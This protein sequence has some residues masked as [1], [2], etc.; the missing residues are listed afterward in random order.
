MDEE[1]FEVGASDDS[2]S[3]DD[4]KPVEVKRVGRPRNET[5]VQATKQTVSVMFR[6]NR[7]F[8][9]HVG[10]EIVVFLGRETKEIPREWLCHPDF[11]Q[12][13]KYFTVKGV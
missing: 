5:K 13:G 11:L 7:K 9:L 4:V 2:N 3:A 1:R 8:D 10:R 12:V 6:E